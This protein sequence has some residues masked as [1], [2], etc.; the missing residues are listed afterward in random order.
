MRKKK[1]QSILEYIIVVMAVIGAIIFGA[2]AFL[3][4][5]VSN[6]MQNSSDVFEHKS[7]EFLNVM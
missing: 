1:A 2:R 7:E 6:M 4:P 5:S 3:A